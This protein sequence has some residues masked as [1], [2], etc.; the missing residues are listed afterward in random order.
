MEA[1]L[2]SSCRSPAAGCEVGRAAASWSAVSSMASA[3]VFSS[4]R[5]TRRVP[6][7]GAMSS[8]GASSQAS[9]VWAGVAPISAPMAC[10]LVDDR[11]VA[12]E[13]LAG[14]ARVGLA[15]VV[16]GEVVDGADLPGEQAVA[17]RRV[18][19]E[20]DAELA[21]QRQDLGLEVAGPQ[22]VLGLQR[23]DRV[24][25]VRAADRRRRGLG[26]AE[27]ADLALGDE[28]G[29]RADGLLDRRARVDAVLVVQVD[30]VG[31]EPAQR[32]LDRGRTL[33]GLLSVTPGAVAAVGDEAELGGDH[34]LVAAALDGPPD[35][36]LAVE[37]AVDL[38]GV[39]VG[40]AQV[41]RAVD[42][43]DRLGVVQGAAR[44]CRCRP[45]SWRRGRCGRRRGR[46][47]VRSS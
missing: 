33:A 15:P 1:M 30:V 46:R 18:G 5:A 36:L 7:I 38:G 35:E 40:D 42:G 24:H 9:A 41:E 4:T 12:L 20:P 47:G 39:D 23:G 11:E 16:V 26:Q 28:L 17:E 22:R 10:D 27:V 14:E 19:H 8:P 31:A 25:G 2:A 21:Q 6:G 3:A 34:D 32:A 37:G 43:A 44:S 45:W 13:V 29:Q